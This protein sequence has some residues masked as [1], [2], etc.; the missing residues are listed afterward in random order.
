MNGAAKT[1]TLNPVG[2]VIYLVAIASIFVVLFGIRASAPVLNPI[3]LA[4]VI[5]ITALLASRADQGRR[6]ESHTPR[7]GSARAMAPPA[8]GGTESR[9]KR[10]VSEAGG[11][12]RR[13]TYH[14]TQPHRQ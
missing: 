11:A 9:R 7:S 8:S 4:V 14:V 5:T 2:L 3:L 1:Q 10:C 13:M 6:T 12:S